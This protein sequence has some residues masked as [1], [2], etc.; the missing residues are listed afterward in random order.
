VLLSANPLEDIRNTRKIS[1]VVAN[2][3]FLDRAALNQ[4]LMHVVEAAKRQQ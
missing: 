3:Q 1:M 4:I 2:G